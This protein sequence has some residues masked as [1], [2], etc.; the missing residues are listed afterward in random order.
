MISV[1]AWIILGILLIYTVILIVL[2]WIGYKKTS[3]GRHEYYVAGGKLSMFFV[4]FTYTATLISAYTFLGQ[5]VIGYY[6]GFSWTVLEIFSYPFWLCGLTF[7]IGLKLYKLGKMHKYI[8]PTDLVAHRLGL[9]VPVRILFGLIMIFYTLIFYMGIQ[10]IAMA[11][12]GAGLLGGDIPYEFFLA[13]FGITIAVYVFL[14]GMRG[15]AYTDVLQGITF[16]AVWAIITAVVFMKWGGLGQLYQLVANGP[17]AWILERSLSNQYL[18]TFLLGQPAFA[19]VGIAHLWVRF[20]AARDVK[21]VLSAGLGAA[22]G[23]FV[24]Y[25]FI[26]PMIGGS[27]A[28]EFPEPLQVTAKEELVAMLFAKWIGPVAAVVVLLGVI[29]AAQSTVNSMT[30]VLSSI[31]QVDILEKTLKVKW[32]ENKLDLSARLA[33]IVVV[34]VAL[35]TALTPELPIVKIA[36]SIVW[37]GVAVIS[38]PVLLMILWKRVNKWGGFLG[39]LCGFVS[40]ILCQYV[41]WPEWPHNPFGL[42]EGMI[43][44]LVSIIVTVVVSLL[45]PSPPKEVIKSFYGEE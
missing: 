29:A 9:N 11:S 27:L 16:F 43:P 10:F 21:A 7:I 22:L 45:T 28:V 5:G 36:V 34:A 3:R 17:R 15:V 35:L 4:F 1:S 13:L 41:I 19:G 38:Y 25:A 20:Y 32:S 42:W 40:L 23:F 2:G 14:G 31:V 24:A 39:L 33:T 26:I 8:T 18:F 37:T 44:S 30:L 12:I 6:S